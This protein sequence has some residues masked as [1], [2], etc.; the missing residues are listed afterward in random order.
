MKKILVVLAFLL[1]TGG[2]HAQESCCS[3]PGDNKT[4]SASTQSNDALAM[5][6][7]NSNDPNFVAAHA[8]PLPATVV[9]GRG[10]M[11]TLTLSDRS[12]S[13]AYFVRAEKK[14]NKWLFVFH[15]WWGL[16]DHIKNEAEKYAA[17]YPE[18]NV[19]ALDLYDG[20]VASTP[21]TAAIYS[22]EVNK[23]RGFKIIEAA[24]KNAGNNAE[25][26][27]LG[28][29]M[30][31]G[32][33]MQAAIALGKQAKACVMYYGMP[34]MDKARLKNLTA[35]LLGIFAE[36]DTW[37]NREVV[38]NFD[39]IFRTFKRKY[40]IKWFDAVHAFA[41][42][43]NPDFNSEMAQEAEN[44]AMKFIATHLLGRK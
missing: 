1:V 36:K 23:D 33:S 3:A 14:S 20:K 32:W 9:N 34:E 28:W 35:P 11:I 7:S 41:N 12:K 21:D 10:G 24:R 18:L 19:I 5:F 6:A 30:G 29:C 8:A 16:N 17:A 4:G 38:N 22:K 2:V 39:K 44:L 13:N 27:T 42:P 37:I 43:S 31:G 15:E 25:I 40:E 26:G